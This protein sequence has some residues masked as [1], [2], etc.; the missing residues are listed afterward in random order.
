MDE[1][2]LWQAYRNTDVKEKGKLREPAQAIAAAKCILYRLGF[3]GEHMDMHPDT[4]NFCGVPLQKLTGYYDEWLDWSGLNDPENKHPT[5]V[6]FEELPRET[7]RQEV[8]K[9]QGYV[10]QV[11]QAPDRDRV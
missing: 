1:G 5:L 11:H 10:R 2:E 6:M 4:C 9:Y 7:Q 8:R 3:K